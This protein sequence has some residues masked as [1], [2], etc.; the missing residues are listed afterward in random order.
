MVPDS[1]YTPVIAD[2]CEIHPHC[3]SVKLMC[4]MLCKEIVRNK[5]C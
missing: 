2:I 1:I 5:L 3:Y 4:V